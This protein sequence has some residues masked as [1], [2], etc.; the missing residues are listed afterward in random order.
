MDTLIP[1]ENKYNAAKKLTPVDRGEVAP[2]TGLQCRSAEGS[3][4]GR[5]SDPRSRVK[6]Q[7]CHLCLRVSTLV[8]EFYDC[9]IK[10]FLCFL[11]YCL[12]NVVVFFCWMPL[13][14]L[15]VQKPELFKMK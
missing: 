6:W 13:S 9:I 15:W 10:I 7:R 3:R 8:C 11:I 4:S 5:N 12:S 2:T 1:R 14:R